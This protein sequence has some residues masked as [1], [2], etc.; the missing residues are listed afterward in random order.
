MPRR[1][2]EWPQ[3]CASAAGTNAEDR[4]SSENDPKTMS[5]DANLPRLSSPLS[6]TITRGKL[7]YRKELAGD[8]ISKRF[9]VDE[10]LSHLEHSLSEMPIHQ[11]LAEMQSCCS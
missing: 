3:S 5:G 8:L 4:T 7:I 6:E 1:S 11:N 9:C 10:D 2:S